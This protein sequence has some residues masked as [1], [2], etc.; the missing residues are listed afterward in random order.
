MSDDPKAIPHACQIPS[1]ATVPGMDARGLAG[2][3]VEFNGKPV[4]IHKLLELP[5]NLD[6]SRFVH[7]LSNLRGDDP[8]CGKLLRKV[9]ACRLIWQ[10]V[11]C[12]FLTNN[13][14][15]V[16]GGDGG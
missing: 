15:Q 6:P 16:L 1:P 2:K 3:L 8:Q 11:A 13:V 14:W 5:A 4:Y 12:S 10:A 7:T 9:G